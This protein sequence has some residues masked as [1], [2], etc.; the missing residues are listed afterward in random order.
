MEGS[1][2]IKL[3]YI[4]N[5][6]H[7]TNMIEFFVPI[8]FDAPKQTQKKRQFFFFEEMMMKKTG[9]KT[10]TKQKTVGVQ[11]CES[12]GWRPRKVCGRK[13]SGFCPH[14]LLQKSH[15]RKIP[16]IACFC[17]R[18]QISHSSILLKINKKKIPEKYNPK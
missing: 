11:C 7:T 14:F 8:F 10:L 4:C 16:A 12:F 18:E 13:M 3:M 6:T 5:L 9:A 1:S 15:L 2:F 17:N